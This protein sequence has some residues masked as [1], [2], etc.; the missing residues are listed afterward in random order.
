LLLSRLN[1]PVAAVWTPDDDSTRCYVLPDDLD[2]NNLLRWLVEQAIPA[3]APSVLRELRSPLLEVDPD[4]RSAREHTAHQHLSGVRSRFER[5]LADAQAAL[6]DA[7]AA[8]EQVR[9]PLL[10]GTGKDLERAVGVVLRDA[11]LAVLDLD[12]EFA[13]TVSADFLVEHAGR[14]ILVEVKPSSG[15]A[16]EA[17]V[18]KLEGHLRTWPNL[19]PQRVVHGGAM[20]VNHQHARRPDLRDLAVY[21]RREFVEQLVHPVISTPT[22]LRWWLQEDWAAI[23]QALTFD[24]PGRSPSVDTVATQPFAAPTSLTQAPARRWWRRTS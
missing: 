11:G 20:I 5:E 18:G 17:L 12:K 22:L 19:R 24:E 14:R 7:R 8:A 1:E 9:Y 16:G 23:R 3:Y 4:L 15:T 10:Y 6:D 13:G 2:W 21:Q